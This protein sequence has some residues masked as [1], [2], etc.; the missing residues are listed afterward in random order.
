MNKSKFPISQAA[1]ANTFMKVDILVN[2]FDSHGLF[3][4]VLIFSQDRFQS[5]L[6]NGLASTR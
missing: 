4:L 5:F 1:E 3:S 6:F 2:E